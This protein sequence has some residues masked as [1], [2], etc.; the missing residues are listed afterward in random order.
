MISKLNLLDAESL[1]QV[2][3]D[4]WCGISLC[5]KLNTSSLRE[6]GDGGPVVADEADSHRTAT[7]CTEP[8]EVPYTETDE[9]PAGR[10]VRRS[11]R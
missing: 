5:F 9:S 8:T 1:M 2:W 6:A 10:R 3:F 4:I 11:H 7:D